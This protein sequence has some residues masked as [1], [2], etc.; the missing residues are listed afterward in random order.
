MG[1][2]DPG[3]QGSG[4]VTMDTSPREAIKEYSLNYRGPNILIEG[5][6]LN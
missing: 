2:L 6:L 1:C 4:R 5:I 3:L